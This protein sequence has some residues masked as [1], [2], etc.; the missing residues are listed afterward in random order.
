MDSPW[1]TAP[2]PTFLESS[3]RADVKQLI[4]ASTYR[5]LDIRGQISNN[6][7]RRGQK[8]SIRAGPLSWPRIWWPLK[9]SSPKGQQIVLGLSSNTLQS[10]KPIGATVAEILWSVQKYRHSRFNI[11]QNVYYRFLLL[12][13]SDNENLRVPYSTVSF[14]MTLSNV[15]KFSTTRSVARPLCNSIVSR[16]YGLLY[17]SS[18]WS[19]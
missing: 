15:A 11:R 3:R 5:F 8:W 7:C 9:I 14:R 19:L 1:A 13:L 17:G 2:W 4:N 6:R 12:R 18:E 16:K 10:F